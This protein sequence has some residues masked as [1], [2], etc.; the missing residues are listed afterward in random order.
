MNNLYFRWLC[1]L[2]DGGQDYRLLLKHLHKVPFY[3]RIPNDDNRCGDGLRLRELYEDETGHMASSSF[4]CTVLEMLIGLAQR[5]EFHLYG[6][7]SELS[8]SECFWIFIKNLDMDWCDNHIYFED[9]C[10]DR[11][12][13]KLEIFLKRRYGRNGVGGIFPL[14][15]SNV[16]QRRVEI[17]Y[18][19]MSYLMENYKF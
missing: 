10:A 19:M 13:E 4:P 5:M 3:S 15:H 7:N 2:V 17:W 1:D 9:G 8:V 18:Q 12:N 6:T 16:D 11:I 14:R